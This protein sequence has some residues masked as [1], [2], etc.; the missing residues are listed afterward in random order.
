MKPHPFFWELDGPRGF[1]DRLARA[2]EQNADV[3]VGLPRG[4]PEGIMGSVV[5]DFEK[6]THFGCMHVLVHEREDVEDAIGAALEVARTTAWRLA[7]MRDFAGHVLVLVGETMAAVERILRFVTDHAQIE[8]G[9]RDIGPKLIAVLPERLLSSDGQAR[10]PAGTE[11]LLWRGCVD[12][13]D[14]D[15][16]V[17]FRAQHRT[18]PR[19]PPLV[20][21]YVRCFAGTDPCLAER[22][23]TLHDADI[24]NLPHS[25]RG[26]AQERAADWEQGSWLSG[27][28]DQIVDHLHSHPLMEIYSGDNAASRRRAWEAQVTALFPWMELHRPALVAHQMDWIRALPQPIRDQHGRAYDLEG[29]DYNDVCNIARHHAN[30][31]V[32]RELP[33]MAAARKI[34]NEIAHLRPARMEIV[35]AFIAGVLAGVTVLAG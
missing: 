15:L 28:R 14:M 30:R 29:L 18:A 34:R 31:H 6:R 4:A 16:Y 3:L 32:D 9:L 26:W 23:L 24:L 8:S 21:H 22:L 33:V 5:S 2:C 17:R 35:N 7:Q 12:T 1:L 20:M 10:A 27:A 11:V 25:I 19:H 13:A